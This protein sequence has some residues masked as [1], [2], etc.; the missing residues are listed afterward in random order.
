MRASRDLGKDPIVIVGAGPTG[1]GAAHA[2][3]QAGFDDWILYERDDVVGGLSRSVTD[4]RG[5]TWDIGGHVGFSH[6]GTFTRLLDDLLKPDEWLHHERESWVRLLDRW[7]PYPFQN[8]IRHLPPEECARCLEGL[9]RAALDPS[10]DPPRNFEDF[11]IRTFG[12]RIADLFMRPYNVKVWA[13]DPAKMDAGWIADRVAVPDAI[14]AA[15]NVILGRDDVSWGPN[16]RFRFPLRG[17]T[18]AIWRAL[19]ARLP[20][21]RAEGLRGIEKGTEVVRVDPGSRR[22]CLSDGREH[23]YGALISTMPLDRLA[24]VSGRQDWAERTAGLVHS[25]THVIGVGLK[26][27]ASAEMRTKCWMYFPE[28]NA[29]FYRVTHFSLYSPENVDDISVHWSLMAEVSESPDRPVNAS[30]VVQDVVKGLARHGLIEGPEQVAHTWHH[31]VEY[32]YPTPTLGRDAILHSLLPQLEK[33]AAILSRGRFGAWLYEASNMD[34]SY[35]QG[36]EAAEHLL[37]NRPEFTL[38]RPHAVNQPHPA[39]GW[40]LY[41]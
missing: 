31:R 28:S 33:E 32:G 29:P 12:E 4:E 22:V 30:S 37:H 2:L 7:V 34:H 17:G 9:I 5:F 20:L 23:S 21:E 24:A 38:W 26:G 3:H 10:P 40:D 19:A 36:L 6:Y 11:I 13:C 1:L 16:N 27:A 18:G 39:L 8:N 35:M 25:A 15:R 41:R 14:R